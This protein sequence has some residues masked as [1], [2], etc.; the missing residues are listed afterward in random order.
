[1][2][3]PCSTSPISLCLCLRGGVG[4]FTCVLISLPLNLPFLCRYLAAFSRRLI[5]S[6]VLCS[7]TT[8]VSLPSDTDE[9]EDAFKVPLA[10]PTWKMVA[11]IVA[12]MAYPSPSSSRIFGSC[13]F[14]AGFG[15]ASVD[16]LIGKNQLA[17]DWQSAFQ[18]DLTLRSSENIQVTHI[19]I[20]ARAKS[21]RKLDPH[22]LKHKL[23][24]I[25]LSSH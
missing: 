19:F 25:R 14:S 22:R 16:S 20:I 3:H 18:S 17:R 4:F 10:L 13:D 15:L 7:S 12:V 11:L 8:S 21:I 9:F 24:P 1:M 2:V 6:T 23:S 5:S